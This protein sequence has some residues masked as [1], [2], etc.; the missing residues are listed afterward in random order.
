VE[1]TGATLL[2][3]EVLAFEYGDFTTYF[4]NPLER[5]YSEH[6][7]FKLNERGFFGSFEEAMRYSEYSNEKD[8]NGEYF[9]LPWAIFSY[10][11]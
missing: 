3:Y 2:G 4:S 5:D 9:W 10:S 8:E 7:D 6:F 11:R 1:E